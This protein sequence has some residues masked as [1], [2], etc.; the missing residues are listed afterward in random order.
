MLDYYREEEA[1]LAAQRQRLAK[2]SGG[3]AASAD[4]HRLEL[5]VNIA[6]AAEA[7]QGFAQG[8]DGVGLFRTEMLFMDADEPPGEDEQFQCYAEVVRLAAGRPV[9]IRTFDIGGDKPARCLPAPQES[10]P[11]LG[12]RAIRMYPDQE[13]VFRA[14]LRAILRASAL[15]PVKVMIPMVA[16]LGEARWV[17][18]LLEEERAALGRAEPVPLGIMLEVPSVLFQLDAFCR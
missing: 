18:R 2:A 8:A 4:G 13:A 1:L 7:Q 10:N 15:G 3:I 12:Y 9:I 5:A 16:T 6:F 11:F 14:Q 17:R